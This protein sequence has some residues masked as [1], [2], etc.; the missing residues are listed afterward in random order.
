MNESTPAPTQVDF[1]QALRKD[2]FIGW[3]ITAIIQPEQVNT[4]FPDGGKMGNA[5]VMLT[6]NGVALDVMPALDRLHDSFDNMVRKAAE[7]IVDERLGTPLAALE[8]AIREVGELAKDVL[9]QPKTP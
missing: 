4:I 5:E 2:E 1:H 8:E 6:V 3:L 7:K 9:D